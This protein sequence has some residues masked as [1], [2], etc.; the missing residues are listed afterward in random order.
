VQLQ[1]EQQVL[2]ECM[3]AQVQ[4]QVLVLPYQLLKYRRGNWSFHHHLEQLQH[5]C[6]IG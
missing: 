5:Q 6:S 4:L 1:L 3:I 2:E